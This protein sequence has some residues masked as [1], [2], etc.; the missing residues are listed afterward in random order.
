MKTLTL[1][2]ILLSV[3][4]TA[5]LTPHL[6]QPTRAQNQFVALTFHDVRDDVKKQGDHDVYAISTRNLSSFFDWMKA[7]DWTPITLKQIQQAKKLGNPLPKNAV[8][9]CFDDGALS[10]YL[11]V[12]PLL[13]HYNVPAVFAIP[14]SWINGN[15]QAA[16][17]AYGEGNLMTWSQM[18]EMQASGLAEFASHS[19]DLHH[20]ILAN[21]Q[22]N[23]KPAAISY[24]YFPEQHRYETDNEFKQ[25]IYHDLQQSKQV[26]DKELGGDS[27]AI[28]WP[29][30]A[31]TTEVAEVA[32]QA[33]FSMSFSLGQAFTN[34]NQQTGT[35][36]R[37][38]IMGNPTPEQIAGSVRS[39]GKYVSEP[40]YPPFRMIHFD[41]MKLETDLQDESEPSLGRLL[42]Q[43]EV[44]KSNVL[45][46]DGLAK[47][48]HQGPY[49]KAY[50]PTFHL[51]QS[52]DMLSRIA[53]QARTR[54]GQLVIVNLPIFP[55]V[56]KPDQVVDLARDAARFN[57]SINSISLDSEQFLDCLW[58]D[59]ITTFECQNNVK[60]VLHLQQ[61]IQEAIRPY[62][63]MSS[64]YFPSLKVSVGQA[65]ARAI[66]QA[67]HQLQLEDSL[68]IL[69]IDVLK[70]P[71]V[72]HDLLWAI[73]QLT[74]QKKKH[75]AIHLTTPE[76]LNDVQ[77][78][79]LR[80]SFLLLREHG[81]QKLGITPHHLYS[82]EAIHRQLYSVLSLN[83]S[84]MTY[85][86]FNHDSNGAAQ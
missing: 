82:G 81:I 35:Y 10:S 63:D 74:D 22:Q 36:Q 86:N 19:H 25:R 47:P 52:V 76:T 54:V 75:I 24:Q 5:S 61:R 4:I 1:R 8:L 7:N 2:K 80:Q 71:Q 21:P 31:V 30:G 13:K 28:I 3:V 27:Q 12:F 20:G 83:D 70:Q 64:R 32:K 43:L 29:Y 40:L 58:T 56:Y 14:T 68:L 33:G 39:A 49:Q 62:L 51:P 77:G 69:E 17:E 79:I 84:P 67:I 55:N 46:I 78:Q 11:K 37:A 48:D 18:R 42:Q 65:Q 66:S 57:P 9:L 85:K 26:L 72:L 16:Y 15:T 50:F 53:W 73:D 41:L 59:Q 6:I 60:T 34:T 23:Q 38:L 45:L 44:L